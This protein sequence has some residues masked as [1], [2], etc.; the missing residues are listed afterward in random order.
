MEMILLKDLDKVGKEGT[1]INVKPGFARNYLLPRGLALP[2]TREHRRMVEERARQAQAKQARAHQHAQ[3]L[4]QKLERQ[5]LTLK[6]NVGEQDTAFGSVTAHD[7][8]EA[9][10]NAGLAVDRRAIQLEEPIKML[11]AYEVPIRLHPE[12]IATLTVRVVKA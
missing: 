9:L 8:H 3:Q 5:A 11:G 2:A 6:L 7:V 4:K 10:A 12:V 1:I